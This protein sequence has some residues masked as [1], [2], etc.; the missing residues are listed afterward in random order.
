MIN[1]L[2]G[3]VDIKPLA[4]ETEAAKIRRKYVAPWKPTALIVLYRT[5]TCDHC[6]HE[7]SAPNPYLLLREKSPTGAMRESAR[8]KS[9][10]ENLPSLPIEHQ[11][12]PGGTIP[13]CS[14]CIEQ[15]DL[16]L[17]RLF[18]AQFASGDKAPR[19]P[20]LTEAGLD[21]LAQDLANLIDNPT[22]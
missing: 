11:H 22:T 14:E 17:Y 15:D 1:I 13:F 9:R 10:L 3:L 5:T 8:P 12:I 6:A 20:E 4:P 18:N 2:E 19:K 7:T 16:D 21:H